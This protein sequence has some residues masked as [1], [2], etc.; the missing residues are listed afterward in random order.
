M[1]FGQ[2]IARGLPGEI[3]R[4][5]QVIEAYLGK[6]DDTDGGGIRKKAR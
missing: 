5:H 3:R 6:R 2:V 4:N 1:D